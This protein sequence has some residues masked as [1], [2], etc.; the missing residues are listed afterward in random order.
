MWPRPHH[1]HCNNR[2]TARQET[3][4]IPD[5][6]QECHGISVL[7]IKSEIRGVNEIIYDNHIPHPDT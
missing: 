7:I 5:L 4:L 2:N 6:D 3:E 1:H